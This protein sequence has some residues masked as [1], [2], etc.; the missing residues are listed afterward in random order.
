MNISNR[1]QTLLRLLLLIPVIILGLAGIIASSGGGG[2]GGANGGPTT[3]V[4]D[5]QVSMDDLGNAIVVANYEESEGGSSKNAIFYN[6]Y[7]QGSGWEYAMSTGNQLTDKDQVTA[8]NPAVAMNAIGNGIV[9]WEQW[10]EAEQEYRIYARRYDLGW[11]STQLVDYR[12]PPIYNG[13]ATN[14]RVA[15]N[16]DGNAIVVWMQGYKTDNSGDVIGLNAVWANR[17]DAATDSWFTTPRPISDFAGAANPQIAM[18]DNGNAIAVWEQGGNIFANRYVAGQANWFESS[19][20]WVALG[21]SPQIAMDTSGNAII[22]WQLDGDI[23]TIR[24]SLAT[25]W[26]ATPLQIDAG[27]GWASDPQIATN[28]WV[29]GSGSHR[30]MVVWKEDTGAATPTNI[31]ARFYNDG[32]GWQA[33]ELI[34]SGDRYVNDPHIAMDVNSRARVVWWQD[35]GPF[36]NPQYYIYTNQFQISQGWEGECR[37]DAGDRWGIGAPQIALDWGASIE[38]VIAV[39]DNGLLAQLSGGR[40]YDYIW[41]GWTDGCGLVAP[42]NVSA[43]A[44]DGGVTVDWDTIGIATSYNIYWN[45]TGGV[46]TADNVINNIVYPFIPYDHTG[47]TNGTTYYYIVTAVNAAVEGPPSSEV[48]ATPAASVVTFTLEVQAYGITGA[49]GN[50]I[51]SPAGID[52][53]AGSPLPNTCPYDF[54]NGTVVRLTAFP[55]AP[56]IFDSW[57][58]TDSPSCILGVDGSGYNYCD[59]TVFQD[60]S[61]M[62]M[63]GPPPP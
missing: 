30:V 27:A 38:R 21:S 6:F 35:D 22:V 49:T 41:N 28:R 57:G 18:D 45:T 25:G 36:G 39:W 56:N 2:S 31:H 19:A 46:T 37:L 62:G 52:C 9:A 4:S 33:T 13:D 12:D 5:P 58:G 60:M 43:T 42:Q 34:E 59:I 20:E 40:V 51:S 55:V 61:I 10:L 3:I 8:R 15:M 47:L 7:H 23:Y 14:P 48:S 26:A 11:M 17:Y 50:V 44:D 16:P 54:V 29:P 32:L 24:Y 1:T 53:D 63:F